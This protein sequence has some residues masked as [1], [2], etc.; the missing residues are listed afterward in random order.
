MHQPSGGGARKPL[1]GGPGRKE[2]ITTGIGSVLRL[3]DP[4]NYV[5]RPSWHE[6]GLNKHVQGAGNARAGGAQ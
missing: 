3:V 1:A 6:Y 2:L 5:R 4:I